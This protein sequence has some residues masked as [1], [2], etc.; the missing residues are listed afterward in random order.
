MAE[1][2]QAIDLVAV[3]DELKRWSELERAGGAAHIS[4]V[5]LHASAEGRVEIKRQD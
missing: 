3:I 2:G 5:T 4:S 1:A